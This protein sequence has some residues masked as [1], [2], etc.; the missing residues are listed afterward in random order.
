[1]FLLHDEAVKLLN[2]I[3]IT[4]PQI[5]QSATSIN[6]QS[7]KKGVNI[8]IRSYLSLEDKELLEHLVK[9][10]ELGLYEQSDNLWLIY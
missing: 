2:E 8:V 9:R 4:N 3:A 7:G 10:R 5:L 1:M 6:L